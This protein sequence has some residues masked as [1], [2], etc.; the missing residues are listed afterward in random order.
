M[1][2]TTNAH[3]VAPL[4]RPLPLRLSLPLGLAEM[5]ALREQELRQFVDLLAASNTLSTLMAGG[6]LRHF[7]RAVPETTSSLRVQAPQLRRLSSAVARLPRAFNTNRRRT[8]H[9]TRPAS[10]V[11]PHSGVIPCG[12][13]RQHVVRGGGAA[14]GTHL[15][16]GPSTATVR[17]HVPPT[18][19]S[20]SRLCKLVHDVLV[21]RRFGVSYVSRRCLVSVHG[22]SATGAFSSLLAAAGSTM[23]RCWAERGS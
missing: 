15:Q 13:L 21:E 7:R 14:Y 12:G 20:P 2:A 5:P 23:V 16:Q 18:A 10:Q 1:S 19:R 6:V 22:S 11:R 3:I 4:R 8:A 17:T 9:S